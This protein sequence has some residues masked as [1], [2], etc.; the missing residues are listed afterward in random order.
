[1]KCWCSATGGWA[2][3]ATRAVSSAAGSGSMSARWV[4]GLVRSRRGG[5]YSDAP[6]SGLTNQ[7]RA[8]WRAVGAGDLERRRDERV[9]TRF[10]PGEVEPLDDRDPRRE[11]DTVH[12]G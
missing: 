7:H 4:G 9:V 5:L 2:L 10:D 11:Q 8:A 6:R 1:M 12:R 3:P